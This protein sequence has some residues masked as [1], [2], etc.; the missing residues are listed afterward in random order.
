[1]QLLKTT[2]FSIIFRAFNHRDYRLFYSGQAISLVGTWMQTLAESW[3]VYRL[4]GSA[5]LLGL[6]GTL[7]LCAVSIFGIRLPIF[8]Q[9]VR[10]LLSQ[11][12]IGGEPPAELGS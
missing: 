2:R 4:T 12:M 7:S 1:M 5:A 8:R 9:R 3:L 11:E 6:I 10:P